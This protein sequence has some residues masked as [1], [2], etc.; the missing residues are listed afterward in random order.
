MHNPDDELENINNSEFEDFYEDASEDS[1]DIEESEVPLD[2]GLEKIYTV[3]ED[4][5]FNNRYNS[6]EGLPDD[7]HF[8]SSINVDDGYS[9]QFLK[10]VYEYEEQLE[11]RLVL[12]RI[13]DFMQEDSHIS[14]ILKIDEVKRVSNAKPKLTKDQLNYIF[15]KILNGLNK[16]NSENRFF[17]P[18]YIL[19]VLSSVTSL[20][21]KKLFDMLDTEIQSILLLELNKKYKILDGKCHKKRIH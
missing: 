10:Y 19:E 4:K 5:I 13:F 8:T 1:E 12:D 11:A 21:Y 16:P 15:N 7:Y 20:G 17:N 6:G 14:K 9:S 18:I 2:E 3:R